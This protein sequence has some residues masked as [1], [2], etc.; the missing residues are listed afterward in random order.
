MKTSKI[1]KKAGNIVLEKVQGHI[2]QAPDHV[3]YR[4]RDIVDKYSLEYSGCS[5]SRAREVWNLATEDGK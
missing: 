2:K 4:V 5:L 3:E 1:L